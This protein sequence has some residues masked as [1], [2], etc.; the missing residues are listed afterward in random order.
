[1]K[2]LGV[3]Y[4]PEQW[5][6]ELVDEDLDN[7]VELGANLIRIGDFAWDRFEPEEG[8]Y[9]FSFFDEVI[10]KAKKRGLKILM[11]VPGASVPSWLYRKHPEIM[12]VDERGY[13]QPF[14]ARRGHCFNNDIYRQKVLNLA[15]AMAEHYKGEEAIVAWQVENEIGH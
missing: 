10:R 7:I 15:E 14:G 5:G 1:M 11:C 8:V 4:Y 6:M 13:R 3:D 2:Y 9:D 12:N